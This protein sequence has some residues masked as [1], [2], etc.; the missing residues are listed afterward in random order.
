MSIHLTPARPL[1]S[2]AYDAA[3]AVMKHENSPAWKLLFW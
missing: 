3:A 2:G 1:I